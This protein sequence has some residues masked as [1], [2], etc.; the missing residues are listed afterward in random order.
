V[1]LNNPIVTREASGTSG[2][3]AAMNASINLSTWDGWF[4]EFGKDGV[5]SFVVPPADATHGEIPRDLE[6]MTNIYRILN[7]RICP[8]Y[9]QNKEA[10]W[11]MTMRSMNEVSP[12]FDADRMAREYYEKIYL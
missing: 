5:N 7:E 9:Y 8:L 11:E 12:Y 2:M 3:T 1:W 10:W 4:C 6:D